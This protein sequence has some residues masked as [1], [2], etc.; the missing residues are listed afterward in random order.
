[1][2]EASGLD[3]SLRRWFQVQLTGG[4]D[5]KLTQGVLSWPLILEEL[6]KVDG[7]IGESATAT[8]QI[9]TLMDG[10]TDGQS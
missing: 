8:T 4:G 5:P 2:A 3:A 9:Q 7:H 10:R 1:M 6:E